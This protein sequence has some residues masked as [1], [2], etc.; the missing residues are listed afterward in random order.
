MS[1]P[2]TVQLPSTLL[3][4]ILNSLRIFEAMQSTCLFVL[5]VSLFSLA[6]AQRR[7][8]SLESQVVELQA[9]S[10]ISDC[11]PLN[12]K[13]EPSTDDNYSLT[14]EAEEGLL[15]VVDARVRNGVLTLGLTDGLETE[16]VIKVTVKVPQGALQRIMK[17][18]T[19]V[20]VVAPGL[21]VERLT[22]MTEGVAA[23]RVF[24]A[25]IDDLIVEATG[26]SI[27]FA[28]GRIRRARFDVSGTARAYCYG[29]R[30][31]AEVFA[32]GIGRVFIDAQNPNVVVSGNVE[33]LGRVLI[34][35]GDC[36]IRGVNHHLTLL[37]QLTDV[38]F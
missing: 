22:V 29:L 26:S 32:E 34:T 37:Y 24:D 36:N 16:R 4:A 13:V 28:E 27:V 6:A 5:L 18:S 14:V 31:E 3:G 7:L 17:S 25:N 11:L 33:A 2:S 15:D 9:F 20:L 12:L 21:D 23:V 30:S 38:C 10:A 35:Q 19:S 1:H 8:P